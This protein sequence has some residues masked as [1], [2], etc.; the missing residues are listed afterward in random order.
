M[1]TAGLSLGD[2]L[3]STVDYNMDDTIATYKGTW[4][5][6]EEVNALC[7]ANPSRGAYC[8]KPR[9][10]SPLILDCYDEC[11]AGHC[12]ASKANSTRQ[13]MNPRT[14]RPA[15]ANCRLS[16]RSIGEHKAIFSLKANHRHIEAGVELTVPYG[17]H[18]SHY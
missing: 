14:G 4:R 17:T 12:L 3:F 5:S 15:V 13:C 18:Y 2:G 11:Q 10:S 16:V 6:I 1:S 9:D 7:Q 8:L